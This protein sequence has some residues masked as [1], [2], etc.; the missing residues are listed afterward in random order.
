MSLNSENDL[1]EFKKLYVVKPLNKTNK[2]IMFNKV[3]YKMKDTYYDINKHDNNN[4]INN[5]DYILNLHNDFIII[6]DIPKHILNYTKI[7]I[8]IIT[9]NRYDIKLTRLGPLKPA[10]TKRIIIEQIYAS[11]YNS[12][13]NVFIDQLFD[14][15]QDIFILKIT[16][17]DSNNYYY[18]DLRQFV[19]SE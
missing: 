8:P 19:I 3:V 7:S 6:D 4:I 5:F 16:A 11:K 18:I 2:D 1:N 10:Q 17:E 13:Y 14:I 9:Y 12:N 15:K